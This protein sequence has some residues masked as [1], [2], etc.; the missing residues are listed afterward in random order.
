MITSEINAIKKVWQQQ[1]ENILVKPNTQS[2]KQWRK[3][4]S[5][6]KDEIKI[7][8][9]VGAGEIGSEAWQVKN[10]HPNCKIIGFEPQPERFEI[11]KKHNYPGLLL[12]F[13]IG[14]SDRVLRG[15]MGYQGGKSDFRLIDH[16]LYSQAYKKIYIRTYTLDTLEKDFG[17]FDNAFI[18]ADVEG[19]ELAVLQGAKR[20]FQENKIVGAN[21]EVRKNPLG[22]KGCTLSQILKFFKNK[23]F[24]SIKHIPTKTHYDIIFVPDEKYV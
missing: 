23:N 3:A 11:L 16:N 20:L 10:T 7:F 18:W 13:P 12:P 21:I 24:V 1:W 17:P 4:A 19:S 2:A 8:I 15:Y 6:L 14:K 9:D 22:P 5:I